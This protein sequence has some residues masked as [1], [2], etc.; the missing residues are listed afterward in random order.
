MNKK[1]EVPVFESNGTPGPNPYADPDNYENKNNENAEPTSRCLSGTSDFW[2][3]EE[4][5]EPVFAPDGRS[6][7]KYYLFAA[8][9][10]TDDDGNPID[11]DDYPWDAQH[12]SRIVFDAQG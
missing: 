4:W 12:V 5:A 6:A 10:I 3:A 9:D 1:I 8:D 11:A 2:A 7:T